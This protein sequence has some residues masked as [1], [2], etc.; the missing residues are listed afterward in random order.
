MFLFRKKREGGREERTEVG[1]EGG[2]EQKGGKEREREGGAG[3]CA[4]N[5]MFLLS[6]SKV[7]CISRSHLVDRE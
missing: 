7:G 4:H 6:F 5:I 2:R 1:R 3:K